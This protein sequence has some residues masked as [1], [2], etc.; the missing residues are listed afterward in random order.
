MVNRPSDRL[1]RRKTNADRRG[2]LRFIQ[3][4]CT[5]QVGPYE[6]G[7]N[8]RAHVWHTHR[9]LDGRSRRRFR[10]PPLRPRWGISRILFLFCSSRPRL[11]PRI[12]PRRR[13]SCVPIRSSSI[14]S[15]SHFS[16]PPNFPNFSSVSIQSFVFSLSLLSFSSEKS[17]RTIDEPKLTV[18]RINKS[19]SLA[20]S[21]SFTLLLLLLLLHG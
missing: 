14:L 4:T 1:E 17:T 20:L 10:G 15:D 12:L 16:S 8:G 9:T 6:R 13:P 18:V 21:R 3:G 5:A 19:L 7:R 2:S 11:S